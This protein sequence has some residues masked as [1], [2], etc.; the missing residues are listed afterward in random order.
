MLLAMVSHESW[1][2]PLQSHRRATT[3]WKSG[4]AAE[5]YRRHLETHRAFRDAGTR[6]AGL[7]CRH[8]RLRE[9]TAKPSSNRYGSML[10]FAELTRDCRPARHKA[11]N[12]RTRR[13]CGRVDQSVAS[14]AYCSTLCTTR[15]Y[16]PPA[17]VS[18]SDPQARPQGSHRGARQR[19]GTYRRVPEM[20]FIISARPTTRPGG[21]P[22][23]SSSSRS[24]PPFSGTTSSFAPR[25]VMS[26]L[27]PSSRFARPSG[28]RRVSPFSMEGMDQSN[29][30]VI[31]PSGVREVAEFSARRDALDQP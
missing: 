2:Q 18:L 28:D 16:T 14:S 30:T 5:P 1:R 19:P 4:L 24:A 15:D 9:S 13:R 25:P 23:V 26:L 6:Q 31:E 27:S 3:L 7:C 20:F 12:F 10:L 21:R 22:S 29:D 8:W 11:S 17:A